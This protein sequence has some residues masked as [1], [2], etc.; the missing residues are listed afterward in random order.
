MKSFI[1]NILATDKKCLA[2][3]ALFMSSWPMIAEKL[4]DKS[5]S[6]TDRIGWHLNL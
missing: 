5:F 6:E 1:L 3:N 2:K 4:L